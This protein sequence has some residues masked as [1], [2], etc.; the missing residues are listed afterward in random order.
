PYLVACALATV[1][2]AT[3]ATR[4]SGKAVMAGLFASLLVLEAISALSLPTLGRFRPVPRL[5]ASLERAASPGDPA[6]VFGT[7]IQSLM[8]YARRETTTAKVPAEVVALVPAGG[9]AF[10]LASEDALETLR[11]SA[12]GLH[13][14]E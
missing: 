4:G 13:L 9:R 8:F 7:P 11:S 10:V 3:A 6:V 14:S 1:A 2:L 5:A 12:S